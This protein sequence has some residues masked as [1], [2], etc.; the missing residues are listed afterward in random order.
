MQYVIF[1]LLL[2]RLVLVDGGEAFAGSSGQELDRSGW[3]GA[4]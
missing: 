4:R 1:L 3:L 2:L